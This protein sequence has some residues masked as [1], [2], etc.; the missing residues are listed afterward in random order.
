MNTPPSAVVSDPKA[1]AVGSIHAM[2]HGSR[3]DFDGYIAADGFTREQRAA[4]PSARGTGPGAFFA[5]A[6]WIRASIADLDYE[7]HHVAA[8]GDLVTVNSTMSGRHVAPAVFYTDDG[9]VE[10]VFPPTGKSFAI[11]QSHWFRIA[12]DK[13]IEHWANRD[14]LGMAKALGWVPPTPVYLARMALARRRF[15]H[16]GRRR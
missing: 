11:T 16:A 7:I 12:D 15:R 8:D 6:Q 1:T 9:K 14:D 2:A 3:P 4:P 13:I 5:L 10:T